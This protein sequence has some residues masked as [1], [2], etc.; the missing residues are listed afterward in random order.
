MTTDHVSRVR[1][2]FCAQFDA[3][4]QERATAR[5]AHTPLVIQPAATLPPDFTL[6]SPWPDELPRLEALLGPIPRHASLQARVLV[7]SAP[8][9]IIGGFVIAP[10]P[11][12]HRPGALTTYLSPGYN[13]DGVHEK[14]LNAAL[15]LAKAA[16][17]PGLVATLPST[18][19]E[20]A[21]YLL[22]GATLLKAERFYEGDL[23]VAH[24]R[25]HPMLA[26][27]PAFAAG[28]VV[29][30]LAAAD[31]PTVAKM[32][33]A[34]G[35][36]NEARAEST[37]RSDYA[38]DLSLVCVA[39]EQIVGAMLVKPMDRGQ[40]YVEI[41]MVHPEHAAQS[42]PINMLLITHACERCLAAGFTTFSLSCQPTK[43]V[44]T[45]NFAR[46]MRCR[47]VRELHTLAWKTAS[48]Q[49]S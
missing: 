27:L 35:L 1:S 49:T 14:L 6:R 42:G 10:P 13:K 16:Q 46:R 5:A 18:A 44:E 21:L 33:H 37:L 48:I 8:E 32:A 11:A 12:P 36:L 45:V 15:D 38:H 26:R 7:R 2:A 31:H 41:R 9:R 22:H 39:G 17:L 20:R 23:E 34:H 24:R 25:L 3:L 4:T 29:R 30:P 40:I 47:E 19:P 43:D 28:C